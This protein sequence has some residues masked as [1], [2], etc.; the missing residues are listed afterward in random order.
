[1]DPMYLCMLEFL[2]AWNIYYIASVKVL[3]WNL[4][5]IQE[6]ILF[7]KIQTQNIAYQKSVTK[8]LTIP[9]NI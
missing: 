2:Y 4:Q 3:L 8:C 9:Y 5:I 7:R 1:M 6:Q